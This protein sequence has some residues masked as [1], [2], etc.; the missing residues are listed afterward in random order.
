MPELLKTRIFAICCGHEDANDLNRLRHDPLLK[1]AVGRCP[2]TSDPLCSQSTMSRL[3]NMPTKMEAARLEE[4]KGKL[5]SVIDANP[6]LRLYRRQLLIDIT[7]EGLR[8]QI[9][10]A[11]ANITSRPPP[12]RSFYLP[13]ATFT[14]TVLP[15]RR[16]FTK[17]RS[18]SWASRQT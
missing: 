8:I 9:V 17:A 14:S 15:P 13:R 5:D 4:L 2:D 12:T 7:S 6:A 16:C 18:T 10:D 3:E 1:M 11:T